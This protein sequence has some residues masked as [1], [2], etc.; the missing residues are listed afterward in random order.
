MSE[1]EISSLRLSVAPRNVCRV[2]TGVVRDKVALSEIF[3]GSQRSERLGAQFSRKRHSDSLQAPSSTTL[4]SVAVLMRFRVWRGVSE[5][6]PGAARKVI[7]CIGINT[8]HGQSALSTEAR[9]R[10]ISSQ[11]LRDF[12]SDLSVSLLP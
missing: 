3:T 4:A 9:D 7:H 10:R 6:T 12:V 11:I 2:Q 5:G 1:G 8:R